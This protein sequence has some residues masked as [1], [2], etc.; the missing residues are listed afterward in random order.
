MASLSS[1]ACGNSI[2]IDV[3]ILVSCKSLWGSLHLQISSIP[4]F[5]YFNSTQWNTG[6]LSV[7]TIPKLRVCVPPHLFLPIFVTD[8][9]LDK[10][11]L[12]C[13]STWADVPNRGSS[14]YL[15]K[16]LTH[17]GNSHA[18]RHSALQKNHE[19]LIN[20]ADHQMHNWMLFH[21]IPIVTIT[22]AKDTKSMTIVPV[23]N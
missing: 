8:T 4:I 6:Q 13:V 1:P 22:V 10:S 19:K 20:C 17:W 14:F 11:G 5:C 7:A 9:E 21:I 16:N 15:M 23:K 18:Y 2:P 12:P 3:C